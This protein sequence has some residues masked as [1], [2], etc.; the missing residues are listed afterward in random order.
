MRLHRLVTVV[1]SLLACCGL[2]LAASPVLAASAV[3]AK[4]GNV[5][6]TQQDWDREVQRRL[7]MQVTFHGE[8]KPEKME[9]IKLA[10]FDKV[11]ERAYMVQYA[12]D[13]EIAVDPK[14]LEASWKELRAKVNVPAGM[15]A[16][17]EA[18]QFAALK[19]A[20]YRD[21]LA[22]AAEKAAVEQKINVTDAA[23]KGYYEANQD[24]YFRP[25]LYRASQIYIRVEPGATAEERAARKAKAEG[26]LAQARA[27]EDFYNL[28]YYNSDDRTKY[29]G[30]SLGSFHAGQTV[31]EFDEAIQ[32]MKPGEIAGL[33]ETLYGYHIIR[34]DEVQEPRQLAFE[35]VA[36][37]IRAELVA[38]E[39]SRLYKQW[40]DDLAKK[41]P[42]QRFDQ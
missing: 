32:K 4:V 6:I 24:R 17:E 13:E 8:I 27:G 39:R 34:L 5:E 20:H 37:S 36:L 14:E 30:G 19:A 29:V 35:D 7:P 22:K 12:I 15:P 31:K 25:K 38:A 2:V 28:A 33:V 23:V 10:A 26:L 40:L 1:G 3:V 42:L 41:Y 9:E 16:D 21:L 18:R 11:V